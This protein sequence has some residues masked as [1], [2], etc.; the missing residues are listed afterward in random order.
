MRLQW[1]A[2]TMV[3]VSPEFSSCSIVFFHKIQQITGSYTYYFPRWWT[4]V[5]QGFWL[6][7][8]EIETESSHTQGRA[9]EWARAPLHAGDTDLCI[10]NCDGTHIICNS[11]SKIRCFSDHLVEDYIY[12]KAAKTANEKL[13]ATAHPLQ[14]VDVNFR[15]KELII[16]IILQIPLLDQT[17]DVRGIANKA[18]NAQKH[19]RELRILGSKCTSTCQC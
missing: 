17:A 8:W 6:D 2:N 9:G 14:W 10:S 11:A 3:D 4:P 19:S 15:V 1:V 16:I 12:I 5:G 18:C 7:H 13:Q